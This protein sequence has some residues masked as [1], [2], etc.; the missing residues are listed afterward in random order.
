MKNTQAKK[1]DVI[2]II[3]TCGASW[4]QSGN[5]YTVLNIN[6]DGDLKLNPTINSQ[7]HWA[8]STDDYRIVRRPHTEST[9]VQ[10]DKYDLFTHELK[11]GDVV[12][13]IKSTT[14]FTEGHISKVL[15]YDHFKIKLTNQEGNKWW[16]AQLNVIPIETEEPPP[17]PPHVF[18]ERDQVIVIKGDRWF[19]KGQVGFVRSVDHQ[20]NSILLYSDKYRN[21]FCILQ[22]QIEP[23]TILNRSLEETISK[24]Y[25]KTKQNKTNKMAQKATN[26]ALSYKELILKSEE[27]NL[28][29]QES[30]SSLEVTIATTKRDLAVAK[31]QLIK[32]QSAIP[33][34]VE[35]EMEAY[36]Q[37]TALET[38]LAFAEK[39]LAERF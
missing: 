16:I 9:C 35:R 20:T 4:I 31:Q 2:E 19:D 7:I 24:E 18:K 10:T 3:N 25:F 27:L 8:C 29:V 12:K 21:T 11:V 22:N 33:Y 6:S 15:D 26:K 23:L 14:Y 28:K 39:V 17:S 1:G 5:R 32:T 37:V 34:K 38:G 13:V 30:K 36:H